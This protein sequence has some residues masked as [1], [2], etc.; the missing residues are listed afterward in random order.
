MTEKY[1]LSWREQEKLTEKLVSKLD[2]REF[3]LI[4]GIAR[5]GLVL[6]AILSDYLNLP[7]GIIAA[8]SY[9]V[10]KLARDENKIKISKVATI[11]P[12]EGSLLLVDDLADTGKTL[13]GVERYLRSVEEVNRVQTATLYKKPWSKFTP[14]YFVAETT[15]FIVFPTMK[16]EFK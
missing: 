2:P 12:L 10:G 3:N 6:A 5:G 8:E 16:N 14:T 1:F 9:P 4:I 7:M 11:S 15:K 13:S